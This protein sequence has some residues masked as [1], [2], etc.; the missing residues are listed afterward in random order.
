M[1]PHLRA[2][3]SGRVKESKPRQ[4]AVE[5]QRAYITLFHIKLKKPASPQAPRNPVRIPETALSCAPFPD[6]LSASTAADPLSA[7]LPE[8]SGATSVHIDRSCRP[9]IIRSGSS[10][11]SNKRAYSPN[12]QLKSSHINRNKHKYRKSDFAL[13]RQSK[14][15][16]KWLPRSNDASRR[17]VSWVALRH[18]K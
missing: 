14:L 1:L 6:R 15:Q 9:L 3:A 2:R 12:P 17:V 10:Q 8:N 18:D 5:G 7:Y 11:S 16:N 4:P 13:A